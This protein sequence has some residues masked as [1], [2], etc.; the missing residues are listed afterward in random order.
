MAIR[1]FRPFSFQN[2]TLSRSLRGAGGLILGG[3]GLGFPGRL[4]PVLLA[5]ASYAVC[6]CLPR[7]FQAKIQIAKAVSIGIT[8]ALLST[9]E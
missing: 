2:M 6:T 4:P 1:N 9:R 3:G 7:A 5:S 8:S